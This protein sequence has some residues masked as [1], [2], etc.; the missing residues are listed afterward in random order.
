MAEGP[1]RAGELTDAAFWDRNWENVVLPKEY[2]RTPRAFYLNA[3]LDVIDRFL[4][5]DAS[6]SAAEVGGAPG[7]HLAY[8]HRT[9]GYRI[10]CIDY[11]P[12]GCRKTLENF[13][14]LGIPG[15]VIQAD[16]MADESDLPTF[17]VVYSLGLIEHFADRLPVVERHV[18]LIRPGGMLV[19]GVP[20]F[21]G[22]TGWFM[23]TLAPSVYATHVIQAMDLDGWREFED[24]LGLQVIWK[25]YVGGFE[26]SIFARREDRSLRTLMPYL[27]ARAM[28][29]GLSRRLGFL[30]RI[31]GPRWSGYAMAV[32]RLPDAG[33]GRPMSAAPADPARP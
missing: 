14:L 20:N 10:T 18:R 32:Y 8:L 23:R 26:P 3:R 11:S 7:Q 2:R 30:R 15:E 33:G 12:M 24:A 25:G 16:L 5:A 4:P 31:N 27:V 28:K 19:L 6:L 13:S 22:L 17:D 1:P 29:L 21:R 9:F